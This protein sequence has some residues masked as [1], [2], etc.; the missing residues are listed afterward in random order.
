MYEK[1][2]CAKMSSFANKIAWMVCEMRFCV[3]LN[4][5]GRILRED[6]FIKVIRYVSNFWKSLY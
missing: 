4:P 1:L 5:L 2:I 3:W 6:V